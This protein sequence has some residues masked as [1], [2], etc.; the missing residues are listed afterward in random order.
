M[1]VVFFGDVHFDDSH[2]YF[3]HASESFLKYFDSLEE[4][5][6]KNTAVF[7][8]D[9][10]EKFLVSG[11]VYDYLTQ[12]LI[13]KNRFSKTYVLVGNHDIK[14]HQGEDLLVFEFARNYPTVEILNRPAQVLYIEDLKVLSLPFFHFI[15]DSSGN[16]VSMTEYYNQLSKVYSK[17]SF[18]LILGHVTVKPVNDE[19]KNRNVQNLLFQKDLVDLSGISYGKKIIGHI[20]KRILPYYIGSIFPL[21]RDEMDL[22][23][24]LIIYQRCTWAEKKLPEFIRF[25]DISYPDSLSVENDDTA[26]VVTVYQCDNESLAEDFYCKRKNVFLKKVF[27]L[28]RDDY[29]SQINSSLVDSSQNDFLSLSHSTS[30]LDFLKSF[31]EENSQYPEGVKSLSFE[32]LSK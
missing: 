3:I 32:V 28:S 12:L 5:C 14:K 15:M 2:P 26:Y 25:V 21:S 7:L 31:F 17:E 18:D 1:A 19:L 13:T 10:T 8:G 27:S 9:L 11:R 16:I 29:Y 6:S 22:S 4:N 24:S 30:T 23:R 20:H